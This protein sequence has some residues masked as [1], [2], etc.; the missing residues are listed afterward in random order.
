MN[1][2]QQ[3]S[4]EIPSLKAR[5]QRLVKE[6]GQFKVSE[7]SMSQVLGGMRDVKALVT[8]IS[9]VDPYEGIRLRGYKI[10]EL[11]E[12]LPKKPGDEIPFSGGIYY[13]LLVGKIPNYEEALE[14]EEEWRKRQE[15]P[16]HVYEVIRSMPKNTSP[17]TLF[18]MGILALQGSS[19]F[20][21]RYDEGMKKDEYWEAMLEDSLNLTA[22]APGIAA[23][24]YNH[25]FRQGQIV[26]PREDLDWAANFG[27]RIG[28]EDKDYYDLSRLYFLIHSDHESGNVSAHATYLVSSALSDIFYSTSA[29]M[30][31]L[32]GPLHGR[33]N[34]EAM[35]WLLNVYELF[36]GVPSK[37]ELAEYAWN[38]LQSG[39]VIP[40]YGHAVLR[41]TDPRFTVQLEFGE[42]HFPQDDLFRLAKMVYE[43]VPDV[44]MKQGKAKDPWPNVDAISGAIQHHFGVLDG[45]GNGPGGF[46]TVLFG[47]SRL[48]GVTA[49]TVWARAMG[50]P[51]ERPKSVTTNMLE[52]MV[53]EQ[54]GVKLRDDSARE[55]GCF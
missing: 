22:K 53:E 43:V 4:Q 15:V 17:M 21:K 1:L 34:Q 11:L 3:I 18:S 50:A 16:E 35:D 47:V 45:D 7:V 8:D 5:L 13:L 42:K 33:A 49:N 32:A 2:K 38:T 37:E 44:L 41:K 14:V 46:Y 31:G 10:P 27:Y 9:C 40:G 55:R 6:Y 25:K 26:K 51:I 48:L 54:L 24:I 29:G 12:L 39:K 23:F 52:A 28:V 20:A 36:H 19:Q 30:N